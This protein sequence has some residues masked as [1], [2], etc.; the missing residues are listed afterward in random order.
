MQD[1]SITITVDEDN[2]G[3][4]TADVD[5][6]FRRLNDFPFRSS[7]I[8]T[9][10]HAVDSRNTLGFYASEAKPSNGF[11]GVQR[12]SFKFTKDIEVLGQD[13]VSNLTAPI[14]FELKA[15]VPV[16]ATNAQ[17]LVERQKCIAMLDDDT[18]M[19]KLNELLET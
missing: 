8:H 17:L 12:S 5:Y 10:D 3:A 15:S 4:T 6:I 13:G 7:Y 1:N 2:D 19:D 11:R 16:G 14:I 18:M 9:T